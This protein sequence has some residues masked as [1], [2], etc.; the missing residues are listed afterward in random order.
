MRIILKRST[1]EYETLREERDLLKKELQSRFTQSQYLQ[2]NKR[3]DVLMFSGIQNIA[4]ETPDKH[5]TL[6]KMESRLIISCN[7]LGLHDR[8]DYSMFL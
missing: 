8:N 3:L 2:C 7:A 4:H 5:V 6:L 1:E